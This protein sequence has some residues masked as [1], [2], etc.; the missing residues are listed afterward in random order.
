MLEN[1]EIISRIDL[2]N[3][4]YSKSDVSVYPERMSNWY[5]YTK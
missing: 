1:N 5:A 3:E 4:L 2:L